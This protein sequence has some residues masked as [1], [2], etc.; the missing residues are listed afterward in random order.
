M[1]GILTLSDGSAIGIEDETSEQ[2]DRFDD[3]ESLRPD[4]KQQYS[5][6]FF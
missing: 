4:L 2:E 5:E 6:L 1:N 3:N